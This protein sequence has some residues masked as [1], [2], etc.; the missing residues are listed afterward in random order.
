MENKV[1][2]T[3]EEDGHR[4]EGKITKQQMVMVAS[5]LLAMALHFTTSKKER[6]KISDRFILQLTENFR[7]FEGESDD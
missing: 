5:E 3:F 6:D 4:I 7:S 1:I 2:I